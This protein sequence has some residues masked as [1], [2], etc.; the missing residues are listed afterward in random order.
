V[1]LKKIFIIALQLLTMAGLCPSQT[2]PSRK[3]VK[4]SSVYTNLKTQCRSA[5]TKAEE[6]ESER[7]GQDIPFVCKG[8]GG[9]EISLASHGAMTFLSVRKK[10][11]K[12]DE[13]S[14]VQEMLFISD[15]I[16][17]RK[18]E[19]RLANGVPFAVIFR[20]DVHD[21]TTDPSEKKKIG[22]VLRV[23]GLND[24]RINF[25]VDVK[26][27]ANPNEEARLLAD[28]AYAAPR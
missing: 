13:K 18:V 10:T 24:D 8:Y 21:D 6:K 16:Y 23:V 1:S 9:Y 19:W 20:R 14:P 22:E 12:D 7:L 2:T 27:S 11:A 4:F 25:E 3:S 5:L 17:E 15:P 26:K 28:K